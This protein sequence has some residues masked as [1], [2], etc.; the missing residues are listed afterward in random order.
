M[1]KTLVVFSLF[2]VYTC[3]G[4]AQPAQKAPGAVVAILGAFDEEVR[5]LQASVQGKKESTIGGVRFVSGTLNGRSVVVAETGIGKV[6][7]AMTT[8]LALV[9]FRPVAVIF[10]GIAGGVNPDLNPGDLVIARSTAHHDYETVTFDRQPSRQTRNAVTRQLNPAFFPADSVLLWHAQAAAAQVQLE[11]PQPGGPRPR[12]TTGIVVTGDQF[13]SSAAKVAQLR[14]NFNADATEME[15]AAVAQVC[16]QQG[17]PC[18]VIRS[19]S[20]RADENARNDMLN[21]YKTA[22]RNSAALVMAILE[23]IKR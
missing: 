18:L 15:G 14:T 22:A 12:V 21:F 7:A 6:N 23:K 20:D 2:F 19:L 1:S 5:L 16:Y 8:T 11:P 4:I 3:S 17:V 9:Q 10:T 13:I